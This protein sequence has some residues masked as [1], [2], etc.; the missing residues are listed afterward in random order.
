MDTEVPA[1]DWKVAG[2]DNFSQG[3]Y[4]LAIDW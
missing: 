1:N 4:Y 3:K 2:N